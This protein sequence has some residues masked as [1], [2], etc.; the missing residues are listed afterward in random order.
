[1]ESVLKKIG[2]TD[3]KV[4]ELTYKLKLEKTLMKALEC[5][6]DILFR[7]KSDL[8]EDL[9]LVKGDL[10]DANGRITALKKKMKKDNTELLSLVHLRRRR[11]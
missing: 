4:K 9:S 8:K 3:S 6:Y 11:R 5:K 10:S 2:S 1:M 7:E